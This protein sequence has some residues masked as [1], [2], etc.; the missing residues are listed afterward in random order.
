M[1]HNLDD[2]I[3]HIQDLEARPLEEAWLIQGDAVIAGDFHFPF[4]STLWVERLCAV[5]R[6]EL[7]KPRKLIMAGD[8]WNL[9]TFSTYVPTVESP[10]W[11]Q[12]RLH[13]RAVLA[14]ILETFDEVI[15][16]MGNHDRRLQRF[17]SA[18]FDDSDLLALVMADRE[19]DLVRLDKYK[20]RVR[21]SGRG[22]CV[23]Q[24][25]SAEY[26]ITHPKNYSINALT[27]ARELAL[28]FDQHI[29]SFHEHHLAQG[30]DRY[31]RRMVINGGCM[32]DADKLP[33]VQLDDNKSARMS[34]GF[35]LVRKGVPV[36]FGDPP[37]TDWSRYDRQAG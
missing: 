33:Y 9:D 30:W 14:M 19:R 29:I 24:S 26:R 7:R 27:I 23:L 17:T 11:G 25:G 10:G 37:Q 2:L 21:L 1:S 20:D 22:F 18:T 3:A 32:V 4:T 8:M 31:A 28:K 13:S 16:L 15:M 5:G 6:K 36:L 12:E 34:N 35:V